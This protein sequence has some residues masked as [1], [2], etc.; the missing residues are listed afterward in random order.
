[1]AQA[2]SSIIV[3]TVAVDTRTRDTLQFPFLARPQS[4]T[5]YVRFVELDALTANTALRGIL[6]VGS[7]NSTNPRLTLYWQPS[8]YTL[9][10]GNGITAASTVGNSSAAV[11]TGDTI[12]LR[13]I[14][15][16]TG[17]AQ[18]GTTVNGGAE[19]VSS[20]MSAR[21]LP[22][23]WTTNAILFNA[24]DTTSQGHIAYRNVEI[25]AGVRTLQEMRRRASVE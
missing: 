9:L 16:A 25:M 5:V 19:T 8:A 3:T 18:L 12:E 23:A 14:L 4:L 20:A 22:P 17:A 24:F 21:L 15:P 1:M 2:H 11:N 6:Q 13:A 7:V 10:F